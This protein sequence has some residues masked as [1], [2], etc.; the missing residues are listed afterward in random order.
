MYVERVVQELPQVGQAV[1]LHK[2]RRAF[3]PGRV[4]PS[5]GW[6]VVLL[7]LVIPKG[8]Y[9]P[10]PL[11]G[12]IAAER[13]SLYPYFIPTQPRANVRQALIFNVKTHGVC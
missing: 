9:P 7:L 1:V 3:G 13:C 12:T 8:Y 2:I 4:R 6:C 10:T 5:I 11:P